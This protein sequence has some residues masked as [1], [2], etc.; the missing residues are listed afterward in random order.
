METCI[1]YLEE[2]AV[3]SALDDSS[4]YWQVDVEKNG[5]VETIFLCDRGLYLCKLQCTI[6]RYFPT[7][8]HY[9]RF[10]VAK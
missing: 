6:F 3:S 10:Q 8:D 9:N 1:E 4:G 7:F 5:D 2:A